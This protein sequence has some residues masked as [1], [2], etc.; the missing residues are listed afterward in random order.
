MASKLFWGVYVYF[1]LLYDIPG[2]DYTTLCLSIPQ[3]MGTEIVFVFY[4]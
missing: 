3:W 2:C 4:E 1:L